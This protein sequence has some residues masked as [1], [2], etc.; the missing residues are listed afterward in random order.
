MRNSLLVP[1]IVI[2]CLLPGVAQEDPDAAVRVLT[3][4]IESFTLTMSNRPRKVT[5]TLQAVR[6][7]TSP[8]L[9][10]PHSVWPNGKPVSADALITREQA[11]QL[12]ALLRQHGFFIKAGK[13]YSER[14]PDSKNARPP[15]GALDYLANRPSGSKQSGYNLQV[16]VFDEY[17]YTYFEAT[18]TLSEE[19]RRLFGQ[20]IAALDGNA[21]KLVSMLER[22]LH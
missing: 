4:R 6:L 10:E 22:Q 18:E 14:Q 17:W 11:V 19:S 7:H 2:A 8:F 20:F 13:Y 21:R 9:L 5:Q 15:D 12:I 3:N 1:V 16:T